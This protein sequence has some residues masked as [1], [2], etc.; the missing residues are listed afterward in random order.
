[1]WQ[2]IF[3]GIENGRQAFC[4]PHTVQIDLTD[5]C[6][7]TCIGCWVH[8]PLVDKQEVFP[9]GEKELPREL[10][11]KLIAELHA[12][13][14]REI[15][16]SGSGEPFLYPNIKE[17]I[18]GIK[19]RQIYLTIIT[20]A[21]IM[22]EAMAEF[23]IQCR[24]DLLT[25]S[26]WAGDAAAYV[27][28]HPGKQAEDF[29]RIKNNLKT[30]A[31][32]KDKR[33]SALPHV[34]IYNVVCSENYS[35]I[36]AMAEFAKEA[37][38]DSA[39]FQIIDTVSGK[40]D[41][42]ALNAGHLNAALA[43]FEGLRR[44]KDM[45]FFQTSPEIPLTEL[46]GEEDSDIG[47]IWKNFQPGFQIEKDC[48]ALV[49]HRGY[50][51]E[52][53]II[54]DADNNVSQGTQPAVFRYSF[55]DNQ[56]KECAENTR[57][58]QDGGL[59]VKL[60]NV[61]GAGSFIRRCLSPDA[62]KGVY[63][64]QISGSP[65]YIG[66][67][68]ARVLTNGDVL[69]CCKASAHPLGNVLRET[70]TAIWNSPAYK[71]FRL[72]AKHLTKDAAY[73]SRINCL[74]SCD[75]RGMNLDLC[76]RLDEEKRNRS[77]GGAILIQAGR[78][79]TGNLNGRS[80]EFG[81]GMVTDG[82]AGWGE[83][84]YEFFTNT[85]GRY[86]CYSEYASGLCRPVEIY[87]DGALLKKDALGNSTGGWTKQYV[88]WFK[89]AV[90]ELNNGRHNLRLYTG[91]Y[92]PHIQAFAFVPEKSHAQFIEKSNEDN[93]WTAIRKS[94]S[95]R[96][97]KPTAARIAANFKIDYLKARYLEILGIYDGEYAYR[98][99]FHVQIDP[100]N[101]CN[102]NCIA[103]WC[104][105]PLLKEKRLSTEDKKQ[106]L[107][108]AIVKEL[109]DDIRRMGAT[110]VYYSGSGEPFMHPQIM[111][112]LAYTKKK[113]LSCHVNT[114]FT[115]LN[116][117][118]LK[119]IIDIGVE[120]LTVSAWAAR[121]ETYVM[122]HSNRTQEDFY[123]I[124]DNLIY[125][126]T[127]KRNTPFIKLY[128]V[129]FNMNY[130]ELEEMLEFARDTRSESVEF[131]L[132]DTIPGATDVL[133]LN[134][135]QLAALKKLCGNI[136]G[137]LDSRGRVKDKDV[138][139]FQFDQFLRRIS[140]SSDAQQAK[141]DRNIID[142]MPCYIGWLF[143]R[144]IPN[145]EVHS[146]LKAH[147]IP[148]GSLYLERFAQIWNSARQKKFREKT[149]AYQK[150]DPFFR[151][152]GNDAG[153]KEAGCYKSCD[154]IGRNTWMHS[155][156]M[157]LTLPERM[158]L[159]LAAKSVKI[160]R[161]MKTRKEGYKQYHRGNPLLAG[162]MHG[163]LAFT[164]PEQVVVDLTNKCNLHCLS[165]W[166]YSPFLKEARPSQ[167]WLREELSRDTVCRLIDD[168]A[169]LGTKRIRFT[170]GGEPFIHPQFLEM[171]EY[172]ARK[173]LAAALTTNL[174]MASREDI[175]RLTDSGLDELCVSLWAADA[176]GYCA[177]HPG[178]APA[179]F[180]RVCDNLR[181][182]QEIRQVKPRLTF[183]NVIMNTN[184]EDVPAMYEFA[185]SYGADALYFTLA[186]VISGQTER[187]L[188]ND[189]QREELLTK[190]QAIAA[191]SKKDNIK[192]EFF[193]G[194]LRRLSHPAQEMN[195]GEYDRSAIDKIPCYAGWTFAR[196]LAD[197]SVAPCCRGV[198]KIMGNINREA[199]AKIWHSDT[200]NE[201]RSKAK[202]LSKE[203]A[204]FK[205]IG[206]HKECDN[207]MHNEEAH[208]TLINGLTDQ[209]TKRTNGI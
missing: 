32:L 149:L 56:C 137:R 208:R 138:R 207:L 44:R 150:D 182:L 1:M 92:I 188:L 195:N 103:C 34:K 130:L 111:E 72:K 141:Y 57:C 4:G 204:Y 205:E 134:E 76:K 85:A 13:G 26:V 156:K 209:R 177:V 106:Y 36:A 22:D 24:V 154:D 129:I 11:R 27:A 48:A 21:A 7:N 38:A 155:R 184:V 167:E 147:R 47:K 73:F 114:N 115:L 86:V 135:E 196:I 66:W 179:Y 35:N 8:S 159:K 164:G 80:R 133:L 192:L 60:M 180:T 187:F 190:A 58:L 118:R 18:A 52:N 171:I 46:P 108:L 116:Q 126:N 151:F 78:F 91:G 168:L 63:E 37:D 136:K 109:L 197:G 15:I 145:G 84:E 165:C 163:R 194:F 96:G 16:L 79:K 12:G 97:W 158:A 144:V 59:T 152:I 40:T 202:Y 127:H 107:P 198:K 53:E 132:V 45:V 62:G 117:E 94:V 23:L 82:G 193:D 153:I 146:C 10:V 33:S 95:L 123:K 189:A 102:N 89:E 191:R 55:K 70:F 50:R 125:L 77:A 172:A 140:V 74:K 131:T 81:K 203:D 113:G 3:R 175:R 120:H 68:Y 67:Y 174:G 160:V 90:V 166:L 31:F 28:A 104:N 176:A 71:E 99:P 128:N 41:H 161:R 20:N 173:G 206:C 121:A 43:Q 14:A 75:N 65:C 51:I 183:A 9:Q 83:A 186:D 200:Y 64:R 6:N 30:L 54:A 101:D 142:Q 42:L 122:T 110:E 88:R 162:I 119:N 98:G 100:T 25:V 17:V 39:E 105:S 170:G 49:C 169:C 148:T 201:F 5:R 61:L 143:A 157:M 181:V 69:P 2:K 185:L 93:Y 19:Q 112:I 178:T 29:E 139:I 124:R 199:F 87:I